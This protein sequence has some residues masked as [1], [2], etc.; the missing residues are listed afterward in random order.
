MVLKCFQNKKGSKH[1]GGSNSPMPP[2]T[3]KLDVEI[4]PVMDDKLKHN[5]GNRNLPLYHTTT[6]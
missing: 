5:E 1:Y 3:R 6:R 4:K 2:Q